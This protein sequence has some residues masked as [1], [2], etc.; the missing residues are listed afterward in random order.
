MTV[1]SYPVYKGLQRPLS[2]RGFKGKF[3][4][5]AIGSLVAGLVTGGLLGA[6]ANMFIGAAVMIAVI[7][8]GLY[9]TLSLQKKGLHSKRR[10]RGIFIHPSRLKIPIHVS[11]KK[12]QF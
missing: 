8:G 3:I 11:N 5:Y 12:E 7:A 2:Y 9:A 6:M 1:P 4:A 10:Y